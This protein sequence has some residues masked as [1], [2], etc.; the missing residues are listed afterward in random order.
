MTGVE[1]MKKILREDDIPF[2][3]DEDLQ[4]YIDENDGD[5]NT[6]IYQCAIVKSEDTTM[7]IN[8]LTT[9]DTSTYFRRLAQKYRPNNSGILRGGE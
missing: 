7:S 5:V 1:R 6:A 8:G 4:F 9:A 2:F 3:D